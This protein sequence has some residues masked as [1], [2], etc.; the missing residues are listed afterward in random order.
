MQKSTW[1]KILNQWKKAGECTECFVVSDMN[2]DM[3]KWNGPDPECRDMTNMMKEQVELLGFNQLVK[4][5]MRFWPGA[6]ASL[7]DHC[8]TNA[9]RKTVSVRNI[10]RPRGDHNLIELTIRVTGYNQYPKEVISRA[11]GKMTAETLNEKMTEICWDAVLNCQ[12]LDMANSRFEEKV[13]KVI[14][15]LAPLKKRQIRKN[16]S[17]WVSAETRVTMRLRDDARECARNSQDRG[18]WDRY[19]T[20]KNKCTSETRKDKARHFANMYEDAQKIN[21]VRKIYNTTKRQ[22]GPPKVF[23]L[24][25]RAVSAPADIA[26]AKLSYYENKIKTLNEKLPVTDRDPLETLKITMRKWSKADN[27][28]VFNLREITLM[29]TVNLIKQLGNSTAHGHE[30]LDS[31]TFKQIV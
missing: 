6:A 10:V 13:P 31:L 26:E 19:K 14:D 3:N 17:S 8:W 15:N 29:E 2:V 20:L 27:R 30:G 22:L 4:G 23:Q 18:D 5:D 16:S 11:R 12:N 1:K 25:G 9:L 21:D 24:A 7:I 28:N